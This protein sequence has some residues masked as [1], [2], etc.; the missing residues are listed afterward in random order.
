MAQYGVRLVMA[1]I[2]R[3][4]R[5]S[6]FLG[7][8][9]YTQ[10]KMC[11]LDVNPETHELTQRWRWN[12]LGGQWFG[13]GYHN[14]GIADVDL[15]GRDEIVFGSMVIDDNGKGLSTA[16]LGHGDALHTS[17]FDPYRWGLELFACNES[18]PSMNYRNA[19]T[20]KIY[21]RLQSTS[22]DGRALCGNF[23]NSYPGS[24]GR[25]TQTGMISSV[26]DKPI[27]ELGDFIVWS[28]LNF[29]IY[30][31]G[32]LL[33]E[34]LNSPGTEREAKIEKPGT[35]RIFTSSGCKMNNDSKTTLV[36]RET[37][38]VTGARK[39]Y[40]VQLTMQTC[41]SIQ[42]LH[43]PLTASIHFGTIISIARQ[44]C[45]SALDTTNLLT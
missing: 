35:G 13:Q 12:D 1:D 38:S 6:I 31:D 45:G 3:L 34:V 28:D 9:C 20:S 16:G 2:V 10:H 21:Y 42:P 23:T 26:A 14:F 7:R 11:A 44:W 18:S 32:D 19:T 29:R 30:W 37:S 39:W 22:D 36:L 25:S 5:A 40:C 41:V 8:G 4:S 17:D 43:L 15:D 24:V 27:T 33:S